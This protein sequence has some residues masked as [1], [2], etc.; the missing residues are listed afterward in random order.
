MLAF[1]PLSYCE[2]LPP[3]VCDS[4]WSFELSPLRALRLRLMSLASPPEICL[5]L[6]IVL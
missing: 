3:L 1:T 2:Q 6:I 5:T 4:S